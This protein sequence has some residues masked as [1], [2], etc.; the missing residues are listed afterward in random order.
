MS[1]NKENAPVALWDLIS[2]HAVV[3][4][5]LCTA[6]QQLTLAQLLIKT[7]AKEAQENGKPKQ[8]YAQFLFS[9]VCFYYVLFN[10]SSKENI[11]YIFQVHHNV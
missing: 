7:V 2:R 1:I 4:L 9:K 5:P 8:G 6:E 10:V 11:L 3:L